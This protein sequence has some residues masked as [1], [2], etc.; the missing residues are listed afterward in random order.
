MAVGTTNYKGV[1]GSN[2]DWGTYIVT[3]PNPRYG[4]SGLS[5]PATGLFSHRLYHLQKDLLSITDGTSNTFM[6]GED[7]PSMD[8]HCDWVFFNHHTG[9]CGAFR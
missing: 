6:I 1:C 8:V 3:D 5:V 9:T 4:N 7:I 2:W